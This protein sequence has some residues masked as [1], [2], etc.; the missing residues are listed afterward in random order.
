MPRSMLLYCECAQGMAARDPREPG[1]SLLARLTRGTRNAMPELDDADELR[2]LQLLFREQAQRAREPE[3]QAPGAAAASAAL[4]DLIRSEITRR[5][6][7]RLLRIRELAARAHDMPYEEF[8]AA[9]ARLFSASGNSHDAIAKG[10][11]DWVGRAVPDPEMQK[12]VMASVL[13]KL[14][15]PQ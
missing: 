1:L 6:D 13:A 12:R 15:R 2:R 7:A 11:L 9:Y 14:K 8:T 4:L 5:L 10:M 3:A